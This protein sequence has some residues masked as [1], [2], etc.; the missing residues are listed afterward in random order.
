M[1]S[2]RKS[3]PRDAQGALNLDAWLVQLQTDH[4][5]LDHDALALSTGLLEVHA[6]QGQIEQ[7]LQIAEL[8]LDLNL[9]AH[10][11]IAGLCYRAVRN[12]ALDMESACDVLPDEATELLR[13]VLRMASVRL[14]RMSNTRLQT[15]ESGDQISNIRA[16]V[17]A[18]IDD[19]RVALIKLAERVV[20]LRIAKNSSRQRQIR[21]AEESQ[22]I[23]APM[24]G[25]LGIWHLKWEL[26]DLALRYMDPDAYRNIAGQL[27][28]RRADREAK[29]AQIVSELESMLR[30]G[31]LSA[32][33]SGRAKHIYSIWRKM[34]LKRLSFSQV[35]DVRAVRVL[36]PNVAECYA[37][38]GLIH[39]RWQHVP[40][41][42]DDY[43]AVPKDNGYR[44]IHT[45]VRDQDGQT[46]EVQIR[47]HEMHR[48]AEL[49]VAAHWAYKSAADGPQDAAS[50]DT[51]AD[52]L[53]WLRQT[54]SWQ[55]SQAWSDG[56]A[57]LL[58]ARTSEERV[59]VYTPAGHVVDLPL[60]ATVL[61]FA[62]RVHTEV[63][64][65]CV[66][67]RVDNVPVSLQRPLR[68]GERI[69][70]DTTDWAQPSLHWLNPALGYVRTTRAR[71][72]IQDYWHNAS[73]A[74]AAT[75]ARQAFAELVRQLGWATP[76]ATELAPIQT[77]LG[78]ASEDALFTAIG[79]DELPLFDLL[80]SLR[81]QGLVG[82]ISLLGSGATAQAERVHLTVVGENRDGLLRDVALLLSEEQLPLHSMVA[83][84]G[85]RRSEN[86]DDLRTARILIAIDTSSFAE[87]LRVLV[88]LR[89]VPGVHSVHVTEE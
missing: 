27:D 24:A 15:S 5:D 49:G 80:S 82:Q 36:L 22:R 38:L 30:A 33:V 76:T 47:T 61:D 29:V 25:R 4:P 58:D 89:G 88:L 86:T 28:G 65:S 87:Y 26:E 43:I 73:A 20:V 56:L 37:A 41:E 12:G 52:K 44:S 21:I 9:D 84:S 51:Y 17:T 7:G 10:A 18:L 14:L 69:E 34:Q 57:D 13:A 39:T 79:K 45:A 68:S 32:E 75:A 42:F 85:E 67:V 53:D 8:L 3:L 55:D 66:G 48:E 64:H 2:L 60:G 63:G 77:A 40:S 70:V 1:V 59:F 54:L 11:I 19:A 78:V 23:F 62:Y 71:E 16:M 74:Q 35:Y 50:P 46:L 81:N 6:D 31:D 72:K 83:S